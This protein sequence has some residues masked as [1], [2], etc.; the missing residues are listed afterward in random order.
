MISMGSMVTGGAELQSHVFST[1]TMNRLLL[2][3]C[4]ITKVLSGKNTKKDVRFWFTKPVEV[5][6]I[7]LM[8]NQLCPMFLPHI[9]VPSVSVKENNKISQ[10]ISNSIYNLIG[11]FTQKRKFCHNLLTLQTCSVS[12]FRAQIKIFCAQQKETHTGLK[13]FKSFLFW[14]NYPFKYLYLICILKSTF[15]TESK[16]LIITNLSIKYMF[17]DIC[18]QV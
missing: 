10:N 16:Y 1:T 6:A 2:G 8:T 13:E 7:H 18:K 9:N 17:C 15:K 4:W 3:I 5:I 14:V 12:F 11:Y